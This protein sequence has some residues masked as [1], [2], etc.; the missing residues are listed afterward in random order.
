MKGCT[1]GHQVPS[2]RASAGKLVSMNALRFRI[3]G[4]VVCA[5]AIATAAPAYA[6][7]VIFKT[8][9]QAEGELLNVDRDPKQPVKL[10]TPSGLQLTIPAEQVQRIIVKTDLEKQYDLLAPKTPDT[11]EGHWKMQEWCLDAQLKDQRQKHLESIVRL[12]PNHEAARIALG[13]ILRGNEWVKPDDWMRAQ[14]YVRYQ[15]AWRTRQEVEIDV[16]F[17]TFEQSQN[18]WMQNVKLWF[19]QIAE[20]RNVD[21]SVANLKA[22]KDPAAG[23]ALLDVLTDTRRPSEF[24]I[25]AM[26]VMTA[27]PGG[28]YGA[29]TFIKLALEDQDREIRDRALEELRKQRSVA[30]LVAFSKLLTHKDNSKVIRAAYCLDRLGDQEATLQLIEALVT[31]HT[32]WEMPNGAPPGGMSATFG[33]GGQGLNMGGRPKAVTKTRPNETVLN[34]LTSLHPGVNYN[35]DED[36]WRRW[37]AESFTTSDVNLRREK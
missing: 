15:G 7:L 17:K 26:D 32:E 34:A 22:I 23:P 5:L 36:G 27:L 37:Y 18:K 3:P 6:E 35:Y 30:A 12:D 1:S 24:R 4:L 13:Y 2:Q 25:L 19:K 10:R 14:G 31:K 8:G 21:S 11:V 16:R 20:R 28:P 9:G 33:G 29:S